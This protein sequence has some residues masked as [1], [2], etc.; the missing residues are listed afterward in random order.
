MKDLLILLADGFEEIEALTV[1]DYLRRADMEVDLVA[2][3]DRV[4]VV[5]SHNI[6]IVADKLFSE[7][8]VG[9][10]KGIYIPGGLPGATNLAKDSRIVELCEVYAQNDKKVI[11]ICAG[12]IVLDRANLLKDINYTCYPGFE[13]NLSTQD[14]LDELVVEDGNI[15]TAMG[16]SMAQVLAFKL[17]EILKDT[18]TAKRVK[19]ET[20]FNVLKEKIK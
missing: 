3:K 4:E 18:Q 15:I 16:P 7:I 13:G 14:R 11:A 19:E 2:I 6:K 20:L 5:G 12:P 17:I 8:N 1:C 9:D 10:Y